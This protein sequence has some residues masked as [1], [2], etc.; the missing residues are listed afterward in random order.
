VKRISLY[1]SWLKKPAAVLGITGLFLALMVRFF[2]PELTASVV[3]LLILSLALFLISILGA[4]SEIKT[5]SRS[6]RFRYGLNTLAMIILFVAVMILANYLGLLKHHRFDLTASGRFTLAPQTVKVVQGF[7]EPVKALCFFP[8]DIQYEEPKRIAQDLLEEYRFFNKNFSFRFIDPESQPALA[9]QYK[10]RQYGTIVFINGTKQKAVLAPTEQNFTGALLEVSGAQAKKV[11]FLTGNGERDIN[12]NDQ[13]G[14]SAARMGLIRDLYQ[15]Q[16]LNLT[17][18][19]EIPP[20]CA[21][22]IMA[23]TKKTLSPEVMKTIRSFLEKHGKL[24]MLIDPNP[25]EEVKEI[26]SDWGLT[27]KEGRVMDPGAYV[28]PDM[29]VPAVFKNQYP[30]VV[31]TSGLDTTYFPD[32]VS[33]DLSKELGR[34]LE[35]MIKG[36]EEKTGWPLKA[37]QYQNVAILPVVLTSPESW[38]DKG[39]KKASGPEKT[40]GP[41]ALG[42]MII[43]GGPVLAGAPPSPPEKRDKLTRLIVIGDS[44]FSSNLHFGNGGN[45]DLFLNSVNWLAEEEHLI[46][47]RPK[48]YSF[49]KLL[50]N[51]N[52]LR[53]IRYSSLGLLPLFT[54]ILG[55]IIWWRKR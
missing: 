48:P 36:G 13:D 20:D 12:S 16:S 43:A 15:V 4:R 53:F 1:L 49:R 14:Y 3:G 46:S 9:R 44:D 34:I 30:P 18:H 8:E 10:I 52:Q 51:N 50:V 42:A 21:V 7:K 17:L 27:V 22:L 33:F 37:V 32:A 45:G 19:N 29:A 35:T 5:F 28:A 40:R 2:L 31:I 38:M 26:L 6:N 39:E 54:L 41:Q 24:L 11:Y 25:P 55:G 47:I 23:A